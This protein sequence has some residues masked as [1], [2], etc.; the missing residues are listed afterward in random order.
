MDQ[1]DIRPRLWA[2]VSLLPLGL[3]ALA[4]GISGRGKRAAKARTAFAIGAGLFVLGLL[5]EDFRYFSEM[6]L[7]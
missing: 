5:L 6:M 2:T 3:I 1:T 7:G 4:G